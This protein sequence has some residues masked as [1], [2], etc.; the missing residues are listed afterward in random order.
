MII[1]R[2][3]LTIA[4][5]MVFILGVAFGLAALRNAGPYL[6]TATYNLACFSLPT[7][8]VCAVV[9][10]GMLRSLATGYAAFGSAY[11]LFYLLP[12]RAWGNFGLVQERPSLFIERGFV[13]LQPYL[14][15]MPPTNIQ[16]FM[17]YDLVSQSLAIMLCGGVGAVLSCF[18]AGKYARRRSDAREAD[19]QITEGMT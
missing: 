3:R 5:L 6:A 16:G 1:R 10:Q 2:Y 11:F 4:G 18:I 13:F 15:P 14:K 9:G 8:I 19:H 12:L 17:D 7:A